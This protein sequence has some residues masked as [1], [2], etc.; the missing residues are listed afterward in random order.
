VLPTYLQAPTQEQPGAANSCKV[1]AGLE[2]VVGISGT[3][4]SS[5]WRASM[6]PALASPWRSMVPQG[7]AQPG[8]SGRCFGGTYRDSP[9]LSCS[10]GTPS[11][12][13]AFI[14]KPQL[15]PLLLLVFF[16]LFTT[17]FIPVTLFGFQPTTLFFILNNF[18]LLYSSL[19]SNP[20]SLFLR[21]NYYIP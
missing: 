2:G 14:T 9:P 4:R 10:D 15:D 13:L 7:L 11:P 21:Y 5:Q 20:V 18:R 1:R 16:S 12:P 8:N 3:Q 19:L 6:V 17:T